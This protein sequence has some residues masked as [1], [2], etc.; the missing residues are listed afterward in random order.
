MKQST[1]YEQQYD[2][3]DDD[4]CPI[5]GYVLDSFGHC[6]ACGYCENC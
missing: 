1:N 5:C 2:D 4:R 6:R 3:D